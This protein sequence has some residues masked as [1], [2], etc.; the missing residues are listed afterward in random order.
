MTPATL[1]EAL[2]PPLF[3]LFDQ[4]ARLETAC[5]AQELRAYRHQVAAFSQAAKAQQAHGLAYVGM[6][7][8]SGVGQLAAAQRDV[9][10]EERIALCDWPAHVMREVMTGSA[11]PAAWTVLHGMRHHAWYPELPDDFVGVIEERLHEDARRFADPEAVQNELAQGIED[12]A[13]AMQGVAA[14]M[15]IEETLSFADDEAVMASEIELTAEPEFEPQMTQQPGTE[16]TP[17]PPRSSGVAVEELAALRD[18]LAALQ[19]EFSPWLAAPV[20]VPS[21]DPTFEIYTD[22]VQNLLNAT[23]TI[24]ID[25][26][27][28]VLE[29]VLINASMLRVSTEPLPAD[30]R[31]LLAIW[32]ERAMAYIDAPQSTDAAGALV[33]IA[34][35][36]AWPG[37]ASAEEAA[38]WAPAMNQLEVVAARA[39]SDR[40]T[41]AL[42]EHVDLG[43]PSDIDRNVLDSLLVELPQHAQEFSALVQRLSAGGTL[44]DMEHARRVAHTLKGA[45]NTV[46]IKGVGNLTHALEDILVALGRE[47]RLPTAAL[48]ETLVEAADCLEAMSESLVSGTAAPSESLAVHQ[49]VLDW[50][51]RI[52]REGL[53]ADDETMPAA[54]SI[55]R[56]EPAAREDDIP[57]NE[58]PTAETAPEESETFLRVPASLIDTLLKLAGETSIVSSQIQDRVARLGSDLT[59]LRGGSRQFGQLT[60]EL[61]QLVDVRGG[62]M[63]SGREGELDALEMD[64]YNELHMLSRRIVESGADSR[65]FSQAFER[66]VTGLRDLMA[67][68]ERVQ[69]EIQ[70]SIMRTRM[71]A[72]DS[73]SPRLQRTVRQA[74]R[75]LGRNVR[76]VIEGESTLVDTQLLQSILDPLMHMLRNAVDHGIEPAEERLAAGKPA[77]GTI[78]LAFATAGA[79]ITVRCQDDGRGLN[80]AVIRSK[81]QRAGL[82]DSDADLNDEQTMRLILLAGFS[83]R[84]KATLISGRGI[85]MDVVQRAV[86]DLRG[87]LEMASE[88]GNGATFKMLFPVQ[89]S[90]TQ[91]MI[92]RSPRHLLALSVRGVEQLLPADNVLT[93]ADGTLAYHLQGETIEALRLET[94]LG[95][96][97][98]AFK[99]AGSLEVVMVLRDENRQRL[100]V[101]TP[102]LGDSRNVVV[103]PYQ[104]ILPRQ[105]GVD[106]ATILGDGSVAAVLDLPDLLRGL[107]AAGQTSAA[108]HADAAPVAQL[109]FCLVVDD[110]VSVRRT[111]EQLMQDAGYEVGSA[112]DGVD[113]L[114][115]LQRRTPDIV[116]VDLEM[117]RMNG[118]EL[119]SALRNHKDTQR[120]PVIMITSRFTDKH[121]Q[122]AQD[123][124]VDAFLTKPYT[125]EHLLSTMESLLRRAA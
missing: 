95:L 68:S 15:A 98:Q 41:I 108:A 4:A 113:A 102:E 23:T 94:L 45:G 8:E 42:A 84:D 91:V 65:E 76:L 122:L 120:V 35:D 83:T 28:Q 72:V 121:R 60:H 16:P 24:G 10:D 56:S 109:P 80:L 59:S 5:G 11:P 51:N 22:Q 117:P 97:P 52:D 64:Q 13:S 79:N 99:L 78:R 88:P 53:P 14:S 66:E 93:Q 9:S 48:L 25:G 85:G 61:E 17:L 92:S 124:G 90:A 31:A 115:T 96:P 27:E 63:L 54:A 70:R 107:R 87:T 101:I 77:L 82:V 114:G 125:E 106:G 18:A 62:A 29:V 71:V 2:E 30:Q 81:A 20:D 74:A 7:L 21:Q 12:A 73:V 89:L 40:P 67:A 55:D 43:V 104:S 6:L 69:L 57:A 123:A 33:A 37:P 36:A 46:G 110:S 49:N 116:L 38:P 26:F 3:D 39:A 44:D 1:R 75:V 105:L 50:A 19:E 32:P 58:A 103:K 86:I 112:R 111:M 118:L 34:T 100:A 47:E 119:T